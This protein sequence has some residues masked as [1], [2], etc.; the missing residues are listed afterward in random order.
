MNQN[1][2]MNH[3]INIQD[4]L[5]TIPNCNFSKE[6][7]IELLQIVR[8]ITLVKEQPDNICEIL[9]Q[10]IQLLQH[11]QTTHNNPPNLRSLSGV[12]APKCRRAISP[13]LKSE[14]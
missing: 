2:T 7:Q 13:A 14:P 4:I 6:A 9:E 10:K 3:T 1:I 11:P 8:Y 12:E 5:N